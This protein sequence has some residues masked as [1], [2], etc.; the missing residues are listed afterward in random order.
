MKKI[1]LLLMVMAVVFAAGNVHAAFAIRDSGNFVSTLDQIEGDVDPATLGD[2]SATSYGNPFTAV[3][4]DGTLTLVTSGY[5]T[6][7][8][9]ASNDNF[10][11]A[12]GWTWET[13]F[14]IDSANA[15]NKGVW[16]VFV[17]DND[18][19]LAATRIHFLSTGI[20]PDSSGN[21]VD[22]E[23]AADLTD[24]FHVIRGA[25]EGGTNAT[26]I[27]L[28]G[29]KV[30]DAMVSSDY[31]ASE[32]SKIGR[33]GAQTGGG[34]ATIDYIRFDTT[35]AYAPVPE[36]ITMTLFGL[37]GIAVLRNRRKA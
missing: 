24:G 5:E 10:D 37:G 18:S 33:W 25:V 30:Y 7:E 26:T 29:V 35:G 32:F 14:R 13:R 1:G 15:E 12:V 16:E 31:N 17:R 3:N 4:G 36:P 27:W 2:W 6:I 34:T 9:D 28:D 21:G 23:V 20:D 19:G 11:S 22:A 8:H